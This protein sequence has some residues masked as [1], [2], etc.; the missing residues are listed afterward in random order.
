MLLGNNYM[1]LVSAGISNYAFMLVLAMYGD[2]A[3]GPK[4]QS[5][6]VGGSRPWEWQ[7]EMASLAVVMDCTRVIAQEAK[8]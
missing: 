7:L 8:G 2:R 6:D 3:V 1:A 4:W 5:E